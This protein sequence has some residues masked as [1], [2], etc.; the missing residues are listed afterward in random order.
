MIEQLLYDAGLSTYLRGSKRSPSWPLARRD[1]LLEHPY[2]SC[3]GGKENVEVHH[4]IPVHINPKLELVQSNFQTL[5]MLQTRLCHWLTGHGGR[6]WQ[7]YN[8]YSEEDATK[9]L[10]RQQDIIKG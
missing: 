4:K 2:C 3:C 5:C 9:I 7:D 1:W 10:Y 8:P 6:S